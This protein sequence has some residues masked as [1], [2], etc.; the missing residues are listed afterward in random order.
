MVLQTFSCMEPRTSPEIK[1]WVRRVA[2]AAGV[3]PESAGGEARLGWWG[4]EMGK[5]LR[6]SA[7][8]PAG[9]ALREALEGYG[10][11]LKSNDPPLEAWRLEQAREALRCFQKGIENW[12]VLPPDAGGRVE[13]RFRART[14]QGAAEAIGSAD[15][16]ARTGLR[17]EGGKTDADTLWRTAEGAM[18]V[19]RMARR[20]VETYLGWMRRYLDWARERGKPEAAAETVQAFLTWLALERKV[21]AAT[22]NQALSALIFLTGQVMGAEVEGLDAVRARRS[23]HLPVVLSQAE[24]RRLLAAAAGT[25]GLML[26]LM[27]GT[28]LRLMECARLRVKDVDFERN[29]VLVRDGKGRVNRLAPRG[30]PRRL[31]GRSNG[32][33][34]HVNVLRVHPAVGVR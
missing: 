31:G 1:P 19:R 6:F 17:P 14:I 12:A 22:Q 11:F 5:F 25:T 32:A 16:A 18:R 29:V 27:Y 15:S 21:S 34:T 13:V 10:R 20:T 33:R 2:A 8:L 3:L 4:W 23:R 7:G 9:T 26:A 28:G 30:E 24:V